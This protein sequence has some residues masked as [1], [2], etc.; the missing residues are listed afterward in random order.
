MK[1]PPSNY[2]V[3]GLV[4]QGQFGRVFCAVHRK[5]GRLVALKDLNRDRLPTQGFLRELR[6]LLS[7][8]HSNIAACHSLEHTATGRRLVLDYCEGG[9]LRP[10]LEQGILTPQEGLAL[11]ADVLAG[12]VHAHGAGI[13][14]CDIKP[15]NV[16]LHICPGGW[17]V[18]ISDFGIARLSQDLRRNSEGNTGSPAYMAPERFYNQS[19]ASSDLYAV[20]VMLYELLLGK[21]PFS[22]TPIELMVAHINQRP[23]VPDTLPQPLQDL[24]IKALQKLPG[25][26]FASAAAMHAAVQATAAQLLAESPATTISTPFPFQATA[27]IQLS[28]PLT[29][30]VVDPQG[31]V[32][33]GPEGLAW[34]STAGNLPTA[35]FGPLAARLSLPGET[36]ALHW[37]S[38]RRLGLVAK[39]QGVYRFSRRSL[40]PPGGQAPLA[41]L[42]APLPTAT[43]ASFC[44]G[45][46]RLYPTYGAWSTAQGQAKLH[47]GSGANR[48]VLTIAAQP[49]VTILGLDARHLVLVTNPNP[50]RSQFEVY[51]RRG[52]QLGTLPLS[53]AL[54]QV[55][56][57]PTPYRLLALEA[58]PTA[59]MLVI[60]LKPFRVMRLRLPIRPCL[61]TATPWGYGV[62]DA[63]G[64]LLFYGRDF[65]YLGGVSAPPYGTLLQSHGNHTLFLA[66]WANQT[67]QLYQVDLTTLGLDILF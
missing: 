47:L 56:L 30:L 45:D 59:A 24:L 32:L 7:L 61:I 33:A 28:Q 21:R 57:T 25:R 17:R 2:R 40:A 8:E 39:P 36:L 27:E 16:L 51:T 20:G 62:M 65:S 58:H 43:A 38:R 49:L 18:K 54:S 64:T 15:E 63:Q 23:Q 1:Q 22:G 31:L 46:Q 42:I 60:D 66:T 41:Q 67:G 14:H 37:S 44:Q 19:A 48:T 4:G 3:L 50:E 6:L 10:L 55:Y 52:L 9:T 53:T 35:K 5:T 11:I 12:L 26:R 34:L 29:Q 13:V